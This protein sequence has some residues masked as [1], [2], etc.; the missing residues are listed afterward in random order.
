MINTLES[1]RCSNTG[2]D[3]ASIW[4]HLKIGGPILDVDMRDMVFGP[5]IL[6]T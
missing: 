3:G 5:K 4:E 2:Q 6:K 1:P